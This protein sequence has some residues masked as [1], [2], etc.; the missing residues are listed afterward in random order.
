MATLRQL[1]YLVAIVDAGSFTRAAERL[2]VAQPSLSHQI[3]SLERELGG[4]LLERLPR[5][6]RPTT[7]GHDFIPEARAAIAHAERARA[8]ARMALGLQAG[9]LQIATI[10]STSAG[11]LP[12]ILR[13]WQ[14]RHPAVELGLHEFTH[15]RSLEDAVRGGDSDLAIAAAP[16]DWSGP[17]ERLGWE[18]FVVVLPH[19]DPLLSERTLDLRELADRRWVHF[20]ADHGLAEV[21]DMRC[22]SSGFTPRVAVRTGQVA[23]APELAAAGLGPTLVPDKVVPAAL[24]PLARRLRPRVARR[25]VCFTRAEWSPVTRAFIEVLHEQRW[26]QRPRGAIELP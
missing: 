18:E 5:G 11:L 6:V 14:Q 3:Q 24:K 20:Q 19:G 2:H 23:S 13:M 17:V 7:A 21:I 8:A 1:E 16:R 15:R 12:P 10:T 26:K 25:V 9:Q 4:A 22:A